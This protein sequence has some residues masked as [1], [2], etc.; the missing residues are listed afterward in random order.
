[1]TDNLD[2]LLSPFLRSRRFAAAAPHLRGRVL[3]FG[4]GIGL[5]SALVGEADYVG[6][7]TSAVALAEGRARFPKA[8][9]LSP[10]QLDQLADETFDVVAALAIIEHMSDPGQFLCDMRKYLK[11]GGRIILT[12]PNP[13]LDWAHGLGGRVGL[14]ARESHEEHQSLMGRRT[15]EQVA[16]KSGMQMLLY[17]RFLCGANQLA[18]LAPN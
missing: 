13:A 2:G 7:D 4:C 16:K 12:T 18:I 10:D 14:F 11:Q 17:R 3:D 1:M 8:R 6:V 5:L 9:F 15:L